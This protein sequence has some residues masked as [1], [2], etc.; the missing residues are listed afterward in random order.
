LIT[1]IYGYMLVAMCIWVCVPAETGWGCS[2][3]WRS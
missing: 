1:C 3:P 2:I